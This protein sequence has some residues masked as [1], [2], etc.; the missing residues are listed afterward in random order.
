MAAIDRRLGVDGRDL[1][2]RIS[3]D[4][5]RTCAT[6]SVRSITVRSCS[7]PTRC[8]TARRTSSPQAFRTIGVGVVLGTSGNT[9]AGGANFW[10]LDDLLRAQKKDPKSPFKKLPKGAEM[11]V[12]MRRSIRVGRARRL[13]P[14]GIRRRARRAPSHDQNATS[15]RTTAICWPAP[16]DSFGNSRRSRCRSHR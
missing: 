15:W 13:A 1:F 10:S 7:S 5:R 8:R 9:G 6:A 12:A 11:I 3:D 16:H 14:R 2:S 4:Q